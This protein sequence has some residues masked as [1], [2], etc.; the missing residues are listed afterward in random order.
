MSGVSGGAQTSKSRAVSISRD[1]AMAFYHADVDGDEQLSFEEF[2]EVVPEDMMKDTSPQQIR[3]LFDNVDADR[4]GHITMDEFF[5]WTLSFVQEST[6]AGLASFFSRYDATGEG[7]LDAREFARAA[8]DL[9]FGSV[10]HDI[11]LELDP[12]QSGAVSYSEL[13]GFLDGSGAMTR[14]KSIS[15]ESKRFLTGVAYSF[16]DVGEAPDPLTWDVKARNANELRTAFQK[17]MLKHPKVRVTTL[18]SIL[19]N[20]S[21]SPISRAEFPKAL[22]RVGLT[23]AP[24]D[25]YEEVFREID[26]DKSNLFG[27]DDMQTWINNV[28]GRHSISRRLTLL[29]KPVEGLTLTPIGVMSVPYPCPLRTVEWD[30]AA[31]QKA[32]QVMLIKEGLAPLDLLRA[33]DQDR[34]GTFSLKEFLV[35]LKKIVHDPELW[36]DEL[37]DI[38]QAA[39]RT[40]AA[41]DSSI[42]VIEFEHWLNVGWLK[43]KRELKGLGKKETPPVSLVPSPVTMRPPTAARRRPQSAASSAAGSTLSR[44]STLYDLGVSRGYRGGVYNERKPI[45]DPRGRRRHGRAVIMLLPPPSLTSTSSMGDLSM[46]QRPT[47]SSL[48]LVGSRGAALRATDIPLYLL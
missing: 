27:L 16:S 6:G 12:D 48:L 40:V 29:R 1:A 18:F 14:T 46:S 32:L 33:W 17:I 41:A 5:I 43:L 37:R 13:I 21:T 9:G 45:K 28:E 8:E 22:A 11:F 34:S 2:M 25:F 35:M 20:G 38:C 31:L 3:R 23:D 44:S 19:S 42:D 7:T 10:G 36:D 26:L 47:S 30:V 4:S 24:S 15:S 39:F